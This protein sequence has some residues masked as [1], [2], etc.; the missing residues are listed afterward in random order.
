MGLDAELP[1]D[2]GPLGP[3][4]IPCFLLFEF[5]KLRPNLNP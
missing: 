1:N 2:K 3:T 5:S 4:K